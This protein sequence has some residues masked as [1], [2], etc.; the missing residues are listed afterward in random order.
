MGGST[1]IAGFW[2]K[3]VGLTKSVGMTLAKVK[4]QRW[5]DT[6]KNLGAKMSGTQRK[7]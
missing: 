1:I 7:I 4:E 6:C 3:K 2:P 5:D